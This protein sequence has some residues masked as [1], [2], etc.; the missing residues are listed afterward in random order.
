MQDYVIAD[1][2]GG[3][4]NQLFQYAAARAVAHYH[5]NARIYIGQEKE[6]IHNY[7]NYD[8]AKIFMKN[9]TVIDVD[10]WKCNEFNQGSS[11]VPWHPQE[12]TLPLKLCGYFQY[13]PAIQP[14]ICELIEEFHEALQYHVPSVLVNAEESMFI[15]VRRGD[16]L[17]LPHYHYNQTV[18]YYEEAFRQWRH[19]WHHDKY[20]IFLVSDDPEWCRQQYWSFPYILY[21]NE[22]EIETMALMSRC[23]AG[24]IIANSSYSYWGAM[25]TKSKNIFYPERWI[26][27]TVHDLFPSGW[28][29][30]SG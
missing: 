9:A 17:G 2:K 5:P 11:F 15:H 24:A 13:F 12:L 4:G 23:R 29:C 7:K 14:V 16:Y 21:A 3:L 10:G 8:Y 6:N 26:A 25:M 27:E 19:R 1:R 22:D 28:T 18:E 30:V 20:T